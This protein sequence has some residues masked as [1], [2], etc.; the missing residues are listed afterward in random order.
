MGNG[1]SRLARTASVAA[2]PGPWGGSETG[3]ADASQQA[4]HYA[5]HAPSG[6]SSLVYAA[7]PMADSPM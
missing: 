6:S 4:A 2:P 3:G 1:A 7:L 5:K